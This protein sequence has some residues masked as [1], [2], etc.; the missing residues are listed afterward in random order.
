M[1]TSF[2]QCH[3][4]DDMLLRQ[5]AAC[6]KTTSLHFNALSALKLLGV[7]M[8]LAASAASRLLERSTNA[9][10]RRSSTTQRLRP[11]FGCVRFA[12]WLQQH[13]CSSAS[14]HQSH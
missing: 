8:R 4:F 1:A 9:N 11:N 7:V 12:V 2:S 3:V 10:D 6:L 13:F 14:Y 5:F